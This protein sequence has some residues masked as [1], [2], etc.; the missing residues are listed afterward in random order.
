MTDAVDP[1]AERLL[2]DLGITEPGEIDVEVIAHAVGAVVRYRDHLTTELGRDGERWLAEDKA[3]RADLLAGLDGAPG[4]YLE[5]PSGCGKTLASRW[6][7]S[8]GL[9]QRGRACTA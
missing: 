8:H 4:C 1:P 3:Q 2:H 5:G 7:G 9:L 6:L